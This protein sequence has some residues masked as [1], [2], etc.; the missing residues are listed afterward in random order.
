MFFHVY[1]RSGIKNPM[2]HCF[3]INAVIF[4]GK[5][6]VFRGGQ[7]HK[8]TVSVLQH[9][10]GNF[11]NVKETVITDVL[12]QKEKP[13]GLF[14]LKGMGNDPVNAVNQRGFTGTRRTE[15]EDFLPPVYR[16]IYVNQR[17]LGLSPVPE[18][19]IFK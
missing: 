3:C 1:K 17:G 6:N 18:G 12:V 10:T 7:A 9:R 4:Q 2:V 15:D 5:G 13:T 14:T 16:Q 11:G 19:E 8:L